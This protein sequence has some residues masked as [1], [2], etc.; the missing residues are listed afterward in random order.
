MFA[1]CSRNTSFDVD[2]EKINTTVSIGVATYPD[3]VSNI[4]YLMEKADEALYESKKAGR[5][6]VVGYQDSL[7]HSPTTGLSTPG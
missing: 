5:N 4:N 2:G 6:K 3:K 7:D 1:H